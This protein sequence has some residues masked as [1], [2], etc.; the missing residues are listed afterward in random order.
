M[1]QGIWG[2]YKGIGRPQIH[3]FLNTEKMHNAETH[4][5]LGV[6]DILWDSHTHSVTRLVWGLVHASWMYLQE[7]QMR[8]G[9]AHVARNSKNYCRCNVFFR[10]LR[11]INPEINKSH[12]EAFSLLWSKNRVFYRL[13]KTHRSVIPLIH[14][15][16]HT[17]QL[18]R[19]W[20]WK[21]RFPTFSFSITCTQSLLLWAWLCS[22]GFKLGKPFVK[23]QLL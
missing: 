6:W 4:P 9:K 13:I 1:M 20:A 11:Q 2:T 18:K 15:T 14:P 17:V 22:E 23:A 19:H 10:P 12:V 8:S 5:I 16:S 21:A 3:I 7:L